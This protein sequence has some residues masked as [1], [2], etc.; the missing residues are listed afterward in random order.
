MGSKNNPGKWDC[1]A[2]AHPD[3]PMFVLLGRDPTAAILVRF[4]CALRDELGGTEPEALAEAY[5]CAEALEAWAKKL[6]K[7]DK[8]KHAAIVAL[9]A[10]AQ[11]GKLGK[12]SPELLRMRDV[13]RH[14]QSQRVGIV[15][16]FAHD[17]ST[18]VMVDTAGPYPQKDFERLVPET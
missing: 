9:R 3:E 13:V 6:G 1:Y 8:V 4:W 11:I 18:D 10:M 16:G 12:G 14:K 5:A 17:G 7:G 2:N 15:T